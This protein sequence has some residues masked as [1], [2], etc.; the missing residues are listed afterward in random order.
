[1]VLR[2]KRFSVTACS[3][4]AVFGKQAYLVQNGIVL[5]PLQWPLGSNT[6]H[7]VTPRRSRPQAEVPRLLPDYLD[8]QCGYLCLLVP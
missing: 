6:V 3:T 5:R 2:L 8:L 7:V 1:M 4:I